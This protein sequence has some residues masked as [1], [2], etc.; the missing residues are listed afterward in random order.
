MTSRGDRPWSRALPAANGRSDNPRKASRGGAL[1]LHLQE[2]FSK[3]RHFPAETLDFS[4][5]EQQDQQRICSENP[6]QIRCRR[7]TR[8]LNLR[9]GIPV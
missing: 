8:V 6:L 1:S 3:L 5:R 7:A 2:I 9:Y 4:L